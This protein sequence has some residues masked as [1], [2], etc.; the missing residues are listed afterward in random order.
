MPQMEGHNIVPSVIGPMGHNIADL[1]LMFQVIQE[2]EPWQADPNVI[3]LPWRQE[4][5]DGV[6]EKLRWKELTFGVLRTDGF[7]DP[8]PPV[9]RAV[10][11]AS[12]AL[13]ARGYKVSVH[14]W[15]IVGSRRS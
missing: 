5:V 10:D 2:T 14:H 13:K 7:V 12:A 9:C 4:D 6:N 15:S 3:R 11:E 8:H 1:R